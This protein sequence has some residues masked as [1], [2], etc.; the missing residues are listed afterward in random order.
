MITGLVAITP[1]AGV[2]T[3]WGA[4]I[5][6]A[7]S[8][9]IPWFSMN[10]MGKKVGL[11]QKIDDT[12]GVFHTHAV[13]GFTGGFCVGLFATAEGCAAFAIASP[14]GAIAGNGRQVWIQ[15]VGALFIIGW[16]SAVTAIILLV[17][18]YVFRI[19]LRMSEEHLLVGDDAIHGEEAYSFLPN[20]H[21]TL[22]HGDWHRHPSRHD[23]ESGHVIKGESPNGSNTYDDVEPTTAAAAPKEEVP[24]QM[25]NV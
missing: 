11:F 5:I 24:G 9:T 1:A 4:I 3:G 6:G 17:I 21:R 14:G 12:L 16:N 19:P 10:M 20:N 13:A 2:V 18:K 22:L 7:L 25:S 15:I 23:T 8:G